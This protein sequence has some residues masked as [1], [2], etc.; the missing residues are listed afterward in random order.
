MNKFDKETWI[1]ITRKLSG[2]LGPDG[3]EKFHQWIVSDAEHEE[4]FK[5][6]EASW[7]KDP[8]KAAGKFFF[9]H[10][11]GL[12]RLREKISQANPERPVSSTDAKESVRHFS[13]TNLKR[14][15]ISF[16][17]GFA[18]AAILLI[19]IAVSAGGILFSSHFSQD[20]ESGM[21]QYV[22]S[23]EEQRIIT[24]SDG[25]VVR[26]NRNSMLR[27]QNEPGESREVWLEGE[28]YFDI[29]SDPERPFT[30]SSGDALVQVLGT[31]FNIKGGEKVLVAVQEGVVSLRNSH[32]EE[33]SA[34]LLSAGQLGI[35]S[36]NG[37]DLKI[38]TADV[39]NYFSWLSGQISFDRMPFEKVIRQLER[40]YDEEHTFESPEMASVRLTVY[41]EQ[42]A[43][44]D[45][46]EA[47][48][49][50]LDFSYTRE[51]D[52]VVWRAGGNE[53]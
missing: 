46:M 15:R 43:R 2:E 45:V 44:D 8:E 28:A 27:L 10:T 39:E 49:A 34:A 52:R 24:L 12:N 9:D 19:A 16:Y 31:S 42:I 29:Q 13:S 20:E 21:K 4:F 23:E 30:I 3:E 32:H 11:Q 6:L 14:K 53:P 37:E 38:E 22:T 26:L 51:E 1:L 25:S 50:A 36:S 5:H 35:L 41:T 18:V 40:I 33:R 48:A 47:I 7:K 17:Q